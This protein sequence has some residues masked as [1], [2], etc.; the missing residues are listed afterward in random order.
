MG[1]YIGSRPVVVQVDGYQREESESRYVNVTG[2]DFSG[3]LDFVDDAK[4]RF[5]DSDE[6][7]I[8][9]QSDGDGNS[10]L[11]G[12]KII[13]RSAA[14]VARLS[15]TSNDVDITSG[16][17]KV[18][19]T[20]VIDST[21]NFLLANTGDYLSLGGIWRLGRN[22]GGNVENYEAE[23]YANDA[24]NRA[25]HVTRNN[26]NKLFTFDVLNNKV[27]S[28]NLLQTTKLTVPATSTA[29]A[30][31]FVSD[32][33]D[34]SGSILHLERTGN[35]KQVYMTWDN[36][37]GYA[38]IPANDT[39]KFVLGT[40]Q[41]YV[42]FETG[43]TQRGYFADDGLHVVGVV[44]ADSAT[45]GNGTVTVQHSG[46]VSSQGN[47]QL[48]IKDADSTNMQ[49]NFIVEDGIGVDGARG[50]LMIQATESGVT[51][52]RDILLQSHGGR[53]GIRTQAPE[54][55]IH[56]N[57]G[58]ISES[59]SV[60]NQTAYSDN[61]MIL[62]RSSAA[63]KNALIMRGSDK[64]G[65]A[66][67]QGR[68][69]SASTWETYLSFKAHDTQTGSGSL[70]ALDEVMQVR[71]S[72]KVNIT[73]S[74]SHGSTQNFQ[75]NLNAPS[76]NNVGI[77]MT[78]G[79]SNFA[80]VYNDGTYLNLASDQGSTGLKMRIARHAPDD[81]AVLDTNGNFVA[82]GDVQGDLPIQ[83]RVFSSAMGAT[84]ENRVIK[85]ALLANTNTGTSRYYQFDVYGYRDI[86]VNWSQSHYTVYIHQRYVSMHTQ[87]V[88]HTPSTA[89]GAIMEFYKYQDSVSNGGYHAFYI[90]FPEDY[91]GVNIVDFDRNLGGSFITTNGKWSVAASD[92]GG[93]SM[94]S[95]KTR[96]TPRVITTTDEF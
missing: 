94:P 88:R 20:T 81:A 16:A 86:G 24:N 59:T 35:T 5:G 69:N 25:L 96:V 51:N 1:G 63:G 91:T 52:D 22:A 46:D 38:G 26:G 68:Y 87:I 41:D 29:N 8:W 33:N 83:K 80:Y 75:L 82:Y 39:A 89:S 3:H 19:G 70:T 7:Q 56:F 32:I 17:L 76:G 67:E 93:A 27:V 36:D 72:G 53:V 42:Q 49:A 21:G 55:H 74:G 54:A 13:I 84:P 79:G 30:V 9:T 48:K 2:D 57:Y 77:Q 64:I 4:A 18:G 31:E 60:T 92:D 73:S 6:L 40:N 47:A 62:Q 44:D 45:I 34:A 58:S 15:I 28:H 37:Q 50:A 90:Y 12:N 23:L 85:L 10:Y 65:V 14:G 78:Q 11:D 66:I 61:P 43:Y 95:G 71:G